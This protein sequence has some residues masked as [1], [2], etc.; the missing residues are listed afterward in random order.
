MAPAI[1]PEFESLFAKKGMAAPADPTS[2]RR[3]TVSALTRR[4]DEPDSTLHAKGPSDGEASS[5][6]DGTQQ[7]SLFDVV[8]ESRDRPWDEWLRREDAPPPSP[9]VVGEVAGTAPVMAP[10]PPAEKTA[11]SKAAAN[12]GSKPLGGDTAPA[13]LPFAV[14]KKETRSLAST[15]AYSHPTSRLSFETVETRPATHLKLARR[16]QPSKSLILAAVAIALI[17]TWL[18]SQTGLIDR[19]AGGNGVVPEPTPVTVEDGDIAAPD[20]DAAPETALSPD[21]PAVDTTA[22]RTTGTLPSGDPIV[23]L[24]PTLLTG[25]EPNTSPSIDLVRIA[26]D[27]AAVLA[28]RAPA[29]SSLIILDN[30]EPIGYVTADDRGDWMFEPDYAMSPDGHEFSLA[31]RSETGGVSVPSQRSTPTDDAA[32]GPEEQGSADIRD[33][34]PVPSSADVPLPVRK[35]Q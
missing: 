21:P 19:L 17:G 31:V 27:G 9:A 34:P 32:E 2:E 16:R 30:G 11:P 22:E 29:N 25:N 33:R 20:S 1:A 18:V 4:P 8:L 24:V 28:G 10:V 35:P 14:P 6:E 13:P 23:E 12:A 15:P 5:G 26:D 3:S 7:A